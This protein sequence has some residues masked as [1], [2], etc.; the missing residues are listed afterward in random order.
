MAFSITCAWLIVTSFAKQAASKIV[1]TDAVNNEMMTIPM[2]IQIVA[3]RRPE[4]DLG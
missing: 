1:V 3:R 2:R 4:V